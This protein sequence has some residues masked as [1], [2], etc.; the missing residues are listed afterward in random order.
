MPV[1][2][3]RGM[4]VWGLLL[5]LGHLWRSYVKWNETLQLWRPRLT[6]VSYEL[7]SAVRLGTAAEQDYVAFIEHILQFSD[8]MIW[9]G[10]NRAISRHCAHSPCFRDCGALKQGTSLLHFSSA[11]R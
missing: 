11:C 8:K 9:L 7:Y 5:Q 2:K 4:Q 3:C 1:H 6:V 10:A